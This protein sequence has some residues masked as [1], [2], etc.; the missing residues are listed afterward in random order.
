MVSSKALQ[1]GI[2]LLKGCLYNS[3]QLINRD[4]CK[5]FLEQMWSIYQALASKKATCANACIATLQNNSQIW[6]ALYKQTSLA[7]ILKEE[8]SENIRWIIVIGT[9]VSLYS[10][11]LV[12]SIISCLYLKSRYKKRLDT[13]PMKLLHRT[14]SVPNLERYR[15]KLNKHKNLP[16]IA[17]L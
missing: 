16:A 7:S 1:A 2:K 11:L 5:G 4:Y 8:E 13:K 17:E 12:L 15:L 14:D 6:E 3:A 10:I 9:L